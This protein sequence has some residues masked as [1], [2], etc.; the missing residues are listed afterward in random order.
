MRN[1]IYELPIGRGR[2]YLNHGTVGRIMEGI[3]MDGIFT[4]Q[5]GH[6]LQVR[7]T[8][9]TQRTGIAAWGYQVGDPFGSGTGCGLT[10]AAGSGRW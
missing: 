6:P 5:T 10:P 1:Y 9:D 4:A 8:L 7:G 3:E 2:G